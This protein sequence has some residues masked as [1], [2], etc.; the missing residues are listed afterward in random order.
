MY[1]HTQVLA[2][3]ESL[4]LSCFFKEGALRQ[5]PMIIRAA[6][7]TRA[8]NRKRERKNTSK[9]IW[10]DGQILANTVIMTAKVRT[11]HYKHDDA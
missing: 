4:V 11:E 2:N 1:D 10:S 9:G 3:C 6:A 5:Q 8:E 7:T